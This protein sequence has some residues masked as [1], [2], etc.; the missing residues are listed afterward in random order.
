M[1]APASGGA[2]RASQTAA[3]RRRLVDAALALAAEGGYE[4]VQMRAVAA[5]AGVALGTL[6]RHYS[7]KDELLLA[8][9][10]DQ[11]RALHRRLAQRPP[12]GVRPAE[13]VAAVLRRASRAL[14][15]TPRATS[16]LVTALLSPESGAAAA[17]VEVYEILRT[18]I[19][20]ALDG[21]DRPDL[22][23]ALRVLGYVW[24]AVLSAWVGG[25][26]DGEQMADDLGAAARLLL[27]DGG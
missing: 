24:L 9:L 23:S 7:S 27:A 17:K 10:A 13:R 18:I 2:A 21:G 12:G 5:R 15:R 8:A 22:E 6:Y 19:A 1:A 14:E 25:M 3:R 11:A 16:A 20:G 4:A 26:L